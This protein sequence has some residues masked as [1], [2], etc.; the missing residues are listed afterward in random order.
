MKMNRLH[1]LIVLLL[2]L[3]VGTFM[4]CLAINGNK[5][6][7][8]PPVAVE[9]ETA[10]TEPASPPSQPQETAMVSLPNFVDLA[11]KV[12]PAVVNISTTKEVPQ[13][14]NPFLNPFTPRQAPSERKDHSLGTGFII[15]SVGHILTNNHV[16]EGADEIL[17]NLDDGRSVQAQIVGRDPRLDIAILKP[18]TAGTY[19][20]V[21]LG[22]SNALEVG[23]WV[24]AVGNP[25]GLGQTVTAGIVS[26]K[27]R[28]LGAGP[29]DDFI[30]TDASINP[31]NSGGPLFNV[32]GEVVGI[33]TA[34][35]ATGQGI[36]FAIPINMA[37]DVVPQLLA[38]GQVTRGWLGVAI[39]DM[40]EGE[41]KSLGLKTS[42]GAMI[43]Q[44]VPG[45]PA[46]KAGV[47]AGD[48]ILEFNG[49]KIETAHS[50]PTV[51]AK[52]PPNKDATLIFLHEGKRYERTATLGS[53]DEAE[54]TLGTGGEGEFLG[55]KVRELTPSEQRQVRAGLVV[56]GVTNGSMAASV[57]IQQGDLLLEMNGQGIPNLKTFSDLLD[58]VPAGEVIRMGLAR[59]PTIYYF[60][61]RKE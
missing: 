41:A 25:F 50:L 20:F 56:T 5:E 44:V 55:M 7:T 39:R 31:G 43:A 27:A 15:D 53:L 6:N 42:E 23:N 37:K 51:V 57:G 52:I 12:K 61:F 4:A 11:K 59:G 34:I 9:P 13:R 10:V 26:A 30:Q 24:V 40:A 16:V 38:T 47:Q 29:Y 46:E 19:P 35:I 1:S 3:G 8:P 22:D 48:V 58:A 28:V 60:A 33:N 17:V 14:I 49:Q 54:K 21:T 2:L 36:G 18:A 45:G 32:N